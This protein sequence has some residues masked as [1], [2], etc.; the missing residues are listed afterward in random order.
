[1]S[2]SVSRRALLGSA[3]ALFA[4]AYMPKFAFAAGSRDMHFIVIVLRGALDGLSAVAPFAD[5]DYASL[6]GALSLA[7]GGPTAALPLDGFFLL[8]P[9]MPN[10]A[11]LYKDGQA[12][13]VHAVA[14]SYRERSHFDGQD[15]LESGQA[16]PGLT[17]T[18]WLNRLVE[19]L[20]AGE[21]VSRQGCLGVGAV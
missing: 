1:E 13:V 17:A 5:P 21:A 19:I 6:H 18:G 11:R 16:G 8:N 10:L 4:W 3:G 20:P 2:P 9:A 12:L 15:V 14:T 7:P